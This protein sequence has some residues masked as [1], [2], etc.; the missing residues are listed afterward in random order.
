[1]NFRSFNR[2]KF[3]KFSGFGLGSILVG[4]SFGCKSSKNSKWRYLTDDEAKLLDSLTQQIIPTDEDPGAKEANV[5]NFIDK[6]LV[7]YYS[8]HQETYRKNLS[9]LQQVCQ[10]KHNSKYEDLDWD[11]QTQFLESIEAGEVESPNWTEQE[12]K[13]FLSMLI[14]HTMQGFYGSPRHGGNKNYVSYQM[15][16]L[17]YPFIIGQNRYENTDWRVYPN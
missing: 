1:M 16:G 9:L 11:T 8:R 3:L 15:I 6:Q 10:Q 5:L 2:R 7:H 13:N 14:D 17:D 12:Q 4:F